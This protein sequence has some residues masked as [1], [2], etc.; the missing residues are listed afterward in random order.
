MA[1]SEKAVTKPI[2]Q[3]PSLDRD[4][5]VGQRRLKLEIRAWIILELQCIKKQV[6]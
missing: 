4:F 6:F 3:S 5:K 1:G 2:H